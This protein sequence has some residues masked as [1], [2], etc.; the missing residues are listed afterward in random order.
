VGTTVQVPISFAYFEAPFQVFFS[1]LAE[2]ARAQTDILLSSPG[3]IVPLE[4]QGRTYLYWRV[5]DARGKRRD[6]YIGA[7]GAPDTET[8][9]TRV[10]TRI[11]AARQF[12]EGSLMLRKQGYA[13][14]DNSAAVT[15]ATLF[16]AG[17]FRHGAMLVGT[18]AFGAILNALGVRLPAN[19]YTEDIDLA[20]YDAIQLAARPE[21]GMLELLERSGLPFAEVLELD[22]R[23]PSTSFRARGRKLRVDLLVPGDMRYR[24][25][26]IPE[27]GA[28]ATGLPFFDY[29]LKS[30]APGV[31]LGRD[32]VVPVRVPDAARY[33]LHK[34]IVASLRASRAAAKADKDIA[35]S[36]VLAAVLIDK[37]EGDL[38]QAARAV[39]AGARKRLA[40]S[41]RRAAALLGVRFPAARDFLE[42][43]RAK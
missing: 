22:V 37:F 24:S 15:L 18:H 19:Y 12:A 11:A 26:R 21:G 39:P 5:Y 41:A 8:A 20:R 13:A 9:L 7:E 27:L 42:G 30:P 1:E 14:A 40:Q 35:Q 31:V 38:H 36:A 2:R 16:N 43:F 4:K 29:L 34:L 3:T 23:K 6:H 25:Y 32:H 17:V 33:C 10:Q 28:H